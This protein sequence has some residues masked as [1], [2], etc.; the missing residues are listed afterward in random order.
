[1]NEYTISW[2]TDG[3]GTVDDTTTVAYGTVP[4][5]A[6]GATPAD[7]QYTY[8]FTGWDTE[9]VAVTG[10]AT[11]TA[12]F[13]STVNEYT[14]SWDTD[15]DGTVDDTATVAYGTVPTHANGS[16]AATAQYTYAFTGWNP[17]VVAVTGAETYTAQFSETVNEYSDPGLDSTR[18]QILTRHVQAV[19]ERRK[20]GIPKWFRR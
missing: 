2:D 18:E 20:Q 9:P 15:G 13:S 10:A 8:T 19:S 16:K 12:Q 7:D 17:E 5:H 4:T 1:M 3:D 14:I 11:Y 6:D